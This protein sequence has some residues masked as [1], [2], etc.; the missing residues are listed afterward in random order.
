MQFLAP[1]PLSDRHQTEQFSCGVE[2][3]DAWLKRRARKNQLQGA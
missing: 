1:V 3:L 2:S